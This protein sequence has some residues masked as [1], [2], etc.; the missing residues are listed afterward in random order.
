MIFCYWELIVTSISKQYPSHSTFK[1]KNFPTVYCK[2]DDNKSKN[3]STLSCFLEE[4]SI[5]RL[6][7]D[8]L[9]RRASPYDLETLRSPEYVHVSVTF[10]S[11]TLTNI[12]YVSASWK[13]QRKQRNTLLSERSKTCLIQVNYVLPIILDIMS[14]IFSWQS[15]HLMSADKTI[16]WI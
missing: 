8:I 3:Y 14:A 5:L 15:L 16:S 4:W 10:F 9:Q 1:I 7:V 2:E 13:K 11:N 12:E 6:K